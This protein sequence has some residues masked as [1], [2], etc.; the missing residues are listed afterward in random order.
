MA[1]TFRRLPPF[2][3]MTLAALTLLGCGGGGGSGLIP[4]P[5]AVEATSYGNKNSINFAQPQVT[6]VANAIAASLTLGDFVQEGAYSAFVAVGQQAGVPKA[7]FYRKSG[8]GW[9]EIS[10]LLNENNKGVC[11]N[12]MQAI[13]ADFNGDGKPDVYVVCG[14][15]AKQVFFMSQGKEYVRQESSF[16]LIDSWGAAAGDIDGD[17]DVDLVLTD[18]GLTYAYLNDGQKQGAASFGSSFSPNRVPDSAAIAA[19]AA[20]GV[21]FPT[22]HRKVFL[23]PRVVN[24]RSAPDLVIGGDGA[25]NNKT[26]IL[27]KNDNGFFYANAASPSTYNSFAGHILNNVVLKPFDLVETSN[28]LYVLTKNTDVST[29]SSATTLVVLRYE[30]PTNNNP[31]TS[32]INLTGPDGT[33]DANF[34]VLTQTSA[35]SDGFISQFKPVNGK[36]VAYDGG[37][38]T[39]ANRCA[40]SVTAP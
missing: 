22:V 8:S 27:L 25:I 15:N 6:G 34:V 40:F 9:S 5:L 4:P 37:C 10:G 11:N 23:L 38:E 3:A 19:A 35:P 7:S 14:G 20:A 30:L 17:G 1:M 21:D 24:G 36:L 29:A 2:L 18:N 28:F 31:S 16:T 26:M 32:I 33:N 12:I 39:L 13:T